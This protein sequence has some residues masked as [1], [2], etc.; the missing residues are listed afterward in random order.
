MAGTRDL[1]VFL[2]DRSAFGRLVLSLAVREKQSQ[3]VT[4]Q[5]RPMAHARGIDMHERNAGRRVVADAAAFAHEGGI[6][7]V[8]Q[9]Y[10]GEVDVGRTAK[11]VAAFA[12]LATD[13]L[14]QHF[15]RA[16]RT[17]AGDDVDRL[18]G[19]ELGMHLPEEI[20]EGWVH[21]GRFVGAPV[22][23]GVV[24]FFERAGNGLAVLAEIDRCR[25]LVVDV[26]ERDRA[27]VAEAR[28]H[29]RCAEARHDGAGAESNE[30]ARYAR[31]RL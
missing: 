4:R 23:E 12:R 30:Q 1:Y 13:G 31:A 19:A 27:V 26:E 20:E 14:A 5:A 25:F 22:T 29:A 15:I 21:A 11:D 10:V 18:L 17:V 8:L 3:F 16:A 9:R 6:A 7:D 28:L 24:E 2:R